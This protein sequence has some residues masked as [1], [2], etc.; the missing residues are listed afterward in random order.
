MVGSEKHDIERK[1]VTILR[2]LN[3]SSEPLGARVIAQR[4]RDYGIYLGERAVRYHLKI[5]DERGLT[6]LIG[7]EGRLITQA[8]IEELR[9]ALV[10][11]KVGF[12]IT[13]IEALAVKTTFDIQ[14][15]RGG[16]PVNISLIPREQFAEAKAT[17]RGAFDAGLCVSKL[18]AVA[19]GGE[20]LAGLIIP[21]G[22]IGLATICSIVVNGALLR[23]GIP[24]DSK[25]GGLLQIKNREPLRFVELIQYTGT[26]LDP[27]E[28]FI[29]SRMTSVKDV[30]TSGEGK[31]LA[32]FREIPSICSQ[33]AEKVFAGLGEAGIGG[34][35]VI[36]KISQP[37]CEVLVELN[38]MGIVLIGGLNPVA[39][40]VEAGIEI[41]SAA[42]SGV[43][44]YRDL[45]S[46]DKI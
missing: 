10:S 11:D 29:T 1:V 24:M 23:A 2:I 21:E 43:M 39:A 18:V 33:T 16:V 42:M 14:R 15:Q 38:K 30:V 37:V 44:E 19:D 26:S 32:N 8:G 45:I 22:K 25:F 9:S 7:R 3:E 46:F 13:T 12:V 27:S 4:F 40:A 41:E 34:V 35:M 5:M 28:I 17:M 36:G 6:R 31:V 20:K